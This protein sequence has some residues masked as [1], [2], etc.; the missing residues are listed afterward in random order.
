[1]QYIFEY[2]TKNSNNW[3]IL[4][5]GPPIMCPP[6][7]MML[8]MLAEVNAASDTPNCTRKAHRHNDESQG[9]TTGRRTFSYIRYTYSPCCDCKHRRQEIHCN[10]ASADQKHENKL[11]TNRHSES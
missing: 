2:F 3:I 4:R 11:E 6:E 10:K 7:A 9:P 5:V 1:M 8:D